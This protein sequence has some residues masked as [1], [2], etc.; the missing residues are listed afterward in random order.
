VDQDCCSDYVV[1][2]YTP[3]LTGLLH[4]R[5]NLQPV[6]TAEA[7]LLLVAAEHTTTPQ[8]PAMA[9]VQAEMSVI[10]EIADRAGVQ[11]AVPSRIVSTPEQATAALRFTTLVHI[12]GHGLQDV[13]S[14]SDLMKLHLWGAF[15][16]FLSACET[17]KGDRNQPDQAIHLASTMLFIGFRSVIS[18]MW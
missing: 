8:L 1:S 5:R 9:S 7:K 6:P 16:A 18:T 12:A 13:V 10:T 11:Y 3:T 17:A 14:M 2:S 15:L 4:A